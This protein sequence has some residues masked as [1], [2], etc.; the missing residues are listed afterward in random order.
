LKQAEVDERAVRSIAER[1]RFHGDTKS[2]TWRQDPTAV[3]YAEGSLELSLYRESG[4]WRYRDTA[5]WQVDDG[6]SNIDLADSA[7]IEIAEKHLEQLGLARRE[8]RV[9]LGVNRLHVGV[10]E[11][12]TGYSEERIIDVCVTFQRVV[13]G[14]PVEGPGGKILLYLDG[15]GAITAVDRLWREIRD[16]HRPVEHLRPPADALADVEKAWGEH[17]T[18]RVEVDAVRLGYF[19]YGWDAAQRYLQPM[20][21]MPLRITSY[22][23]RFV[24][25][26]EQVVPAAI[27]SVETGAPP[28][29]QSAY[30][31]P[32]SERRRGSAEIE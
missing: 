11:Q 7:A 15:A 20:Y 5:R 27:E 4:G 17:G 9:V 6:R 21:I 30:A 28:P 26:S 13:D 25:G 2:G 22:D 24:A 32:R 16:V 18:G 3:T 10:A 29:V 19:E 23:G 14:L 12:A 31:P 8:E 1:F